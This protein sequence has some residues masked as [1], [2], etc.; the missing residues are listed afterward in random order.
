MPLYSYSCERA[1][2]SHSFLLL[3]LHLSLCFGIIF[4]NSSWEDETN[5]LVL[6]LLR[7]LGV[8]L[9]EAVADALLGGHPLEHTAV[10]ATVFAGREGLGGEVVDARGEAVVDEAAESLNVMEVSSVF[11]FF[12]LPVCWCPCL[13]VMT[14]SHE[15]LDLTLLH[16]L[17]K[18]ALLGCGKPVFRVSCV[19]LFLSL[20]HRNRLAVVAWALSAEWEGWHTRPFW[21]MWMG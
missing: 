10:D 4:K 18:G 6:H 5:F 20:S 1:P 16:A 7:Q 14:Y 12:V 13:L 9:L 8:V 19:A 11:F 21:L 17:L 3:L 15:L 2:Q